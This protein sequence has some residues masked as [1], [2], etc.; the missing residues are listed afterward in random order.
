MAI[1][2]NNPSVIR[3]DDGGCVHLGHDGRAWKMM[4]TFEIRAPVYLRCMLLAFNEYLG[5]REHCIG[6]GLSHCF[7]QR[8]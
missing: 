4:A 6:R 3:K 2:V 8:I 7:F 1:G 5:S